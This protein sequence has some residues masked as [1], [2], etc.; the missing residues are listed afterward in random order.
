[1]KRDLLPLQFPCRVKERS[2]LRCC[3]CSLLKS[4]LEDIF[5]EP[6]G[7]KRWHSAEQDTTRTK[8]GHRR[9]SRRDWGEDDGRV[10]HGEKNSSHERILVCFGILGNVICERRDRI[11]FEIANENVGVSKFFRTRNIT[12]AKGK[13][14]VLWTVEL[15][16]N[17]GVTCL[18]CSGRMRSPVSFV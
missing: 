4:C 12:D 17:I 16:G 2:I 7:E 6:G 9:Q 5:K 13:I 14:S 3:W 15:F 18:G 8:I 10:T 11:K 1:M